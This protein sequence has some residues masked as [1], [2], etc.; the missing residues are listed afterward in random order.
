MGANKNIGAFIGEVRSESGEF[1][2]SLHKV[3]SDDFRIVVRS[4]G[5]V[6]S[7]SSSMP[8]SAFEYIGADKVSASQFV[9]QFRFAGG[10]Q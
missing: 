8:R 1:I 9:K 3:S 5:T 4:F 10:A 7:V 6:R 2:G